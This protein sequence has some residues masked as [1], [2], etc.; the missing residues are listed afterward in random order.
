M[1]WESRLINVYLKVCSYWEQ[2]VWCSC[3]RFGNNQQL[4]LSDEEIVTIFIFGIMEGRRSIRQIHSFAVNHLSGWFPDLCQYE[5]FVH[6]LNRTSDAFISILGHVVADL[7]H[8][9]DFMSEAKLL[10]DSAP[11]VVANTARSSRARV[12]SE[13][14]SKGYCGSK[15]MFYY[16]VKLHVG[17][18]SRKTSLPVP[19][20][21]GITPASEH[22]LSAFRQVAASLSN[23]DVFA[24]K[25]YLNREFQQEL[26][27]KQKVTLSTP[28]RLSRGQKV[29]DSADRMY[30][31]AVSSIR[32]P[33]E[34]FFNWIQEKTG[35]Q[36]AS[37]VRSLNGLYVHVFGRVVAGAMMLMF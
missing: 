34:S 27:R 18:M 1:D 24:D 7:E 29:L 22:D 21:V 35:I 32:Q 20:I 30:S 23:T 33:I 12:A 3:Q 28:V 36:T 4:K 31:K 9:Y 16:G 6:R 14:A 10:F 25:A 15:K 17:G 5:G 8:S 11:I 2:G 26:A 37:K 13:I 19:G